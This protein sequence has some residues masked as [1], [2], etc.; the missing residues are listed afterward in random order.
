NLNQIWAA[1]NSIKHIRNG[2][3]WQNVIGNPAQVLKDISG[4][5]LSAVTWVMPQVPSSDHPP[6]NNGT[7][8]SWVS[9]VV[10]AVGNSQY[11]SNTA[12]FITWDDWGGWYDHVAPPIIN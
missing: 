7:G 2:S 6:E 1:P 8:P 3:D 12:I 5:H 11:W 4:N 9:S 10:N